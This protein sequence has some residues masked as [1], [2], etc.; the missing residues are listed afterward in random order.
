MSSEISWQQRF[1]NEL[2][3]I[4]QDFFNKQLL[5]QDDLFTKL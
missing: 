5:I 4:H 3:K 1:E 2:I